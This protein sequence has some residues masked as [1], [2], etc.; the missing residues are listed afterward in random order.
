MSA[1]TRLTNNPDARSTRLTRSP[2]AGAK[3]VLSFPA[4]TRNYFYFGLF[5]AELRPRPDDIPGAYAAANARLPRMLD[6]NPLYAA[7]IT[8]IGMSERLFL[9]EARPPELELARRAAQ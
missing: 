9:T 5:L 2:S 3:A 7:V 6:D 4:Q 1:M 8:R